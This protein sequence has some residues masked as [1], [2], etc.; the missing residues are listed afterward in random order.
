MEMYGKMAGM[1]KAQAKEFAN[2]IVAYGTKFSVFLL[3]FITAAVLALGM[4]KSD[5]PYA[6]KRQKL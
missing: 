5:P 6:P 2:V 4:K 3:L 1:E